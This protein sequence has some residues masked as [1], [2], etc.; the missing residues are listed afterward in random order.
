M[1]CSISHDA[2]DDNNA[3]DN[4]PGTLGMMTVGPNAT[5]LFAAGRLHRLLP[6]ARDRDAGG[7]AV[8]GEHALARTRVTGTLMA[9]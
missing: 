9:S 7:P 4:T 8:T 3:D 5:E 6:P 1:S 2:D